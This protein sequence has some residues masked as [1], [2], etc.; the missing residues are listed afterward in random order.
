[1]VISRGD[2]DDRYDGRFL[3]KKREYPDCWLRIGR[4]V[5]IAIAVLLAIMAL[6]LLASLAIAFGEKLCTMS[7]DLS[8]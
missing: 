1:M 2:L 5:S 7:L 8:V 6:Y 4:M 3:R